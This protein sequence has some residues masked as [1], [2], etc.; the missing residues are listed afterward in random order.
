M[1]EL[2]CIH[3]REACLR[4]VTANKPLFDRESKKKKDQSEIYDNFKYRICNM[5]R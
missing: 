2:S 3:V 5:N 4:L 1:S